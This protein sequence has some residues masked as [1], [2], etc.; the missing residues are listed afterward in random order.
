MAKSGA[1]SIA[2]GESLFAMRVTTIAYWAHALV[3]RYAIPK[4]LSKLLANAG[5]KG[6]AKSRTSK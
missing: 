2:L 3:S 4:T 5:V 1:G 6:G